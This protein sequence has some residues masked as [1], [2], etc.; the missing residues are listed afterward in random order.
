MLP[1]SHIKALV[2]HTLCSLSKLPLLHSATPSPAI[3]S[4]R[5]SEESADA[6]LGG[7]KPKDQIQVSHHLPT[8][9]PTNAGS[10]RP[11][12]HFQYESWMFQ[13]FPLHPRA[14][15]NHSETGARSKQAYVHIWFLIPPLF[16][17]KIKT[18]HLLGAQKKTS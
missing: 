2:P 10:H 3:L 17:L 15:A 12:T 18:K 8:S 1:Y 9:H 5:S 13:A 11:L 6:L 16:H 4:F 14:L 7:F